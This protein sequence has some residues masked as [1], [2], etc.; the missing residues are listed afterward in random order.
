M[1]GV[2]T[3]YTRLLNDS[4]FNAETCRNMRLFISGS[5]PLAEQTFA[6]FERRTGMRI[7]ERYGMSETLMNT[8]NRLDP[9]DGARLAGSVG[10]ALPGVA[11][12]IADA[13]GLPLPAGAVGGIEVRGPNVFKGY[14]RMP[15]KTREEFR[16]D[17][18]FATGDM[19]SMDDEGRIRIVGRAKDL[20]I[21]GGCNVYP[22]EVETLLDT[23]PGVQESAIVGVPHAD[24]GE[25]VV[26]IMV[27]DQTVDLVRVDAFLKD[28]LARHKQPKRVIRVTELPRNALGKVCK[29]ILRD[30]YSDVF[31]SDSACGNDDA[32]WIG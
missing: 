31:A 14:W 1:M 23:L 4:A 30:T 15:E 16:A 26:A 6:A 27:A 21:S 9:L 28:K 17:G 32:K 18:F 19:G 24:F 2:P 3:F 13:D 29:N 22:K 5:A 7:L 25:A 11:V 20:V 8:S 10:F 12:R